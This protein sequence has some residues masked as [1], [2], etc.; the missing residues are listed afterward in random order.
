M[1]NRNHNMQMQVITI[2]KIQK[3]HK[4]HKLS[5]RGRSKGTIKKRASILKHLHK[6]N[7]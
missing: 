2:L 7:I 4:L 5:R 3:L 6:E 1:D